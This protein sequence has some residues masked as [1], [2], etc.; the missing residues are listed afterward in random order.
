MRPEPERVLTDAAHITHTN[1]LLT[2]TARRAKAKPAYVAWALSRYQTRHALTD[3]ALAK[4]L[5][6]DR[7]TLPRLALCLAPREDHRAEDLAQIAG[8]LGLHP[9]SLLAILTEAEASESEERQPPA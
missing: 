6:C 8:T 9:E 2:H 3:E 7:L 1:E 4:Q 5:G